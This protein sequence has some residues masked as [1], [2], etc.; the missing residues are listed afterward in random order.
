MPSPQTNVVIRKYQPRDRAAVH[1]LTC[2]TALMGEPCG[3]FFDGD[4]VFAQAVS[5]YFTGYE[6]ESC[7]VAVDGDRVVG[8]LTGAKDARRVNTVFRRRIALPLFVR[9][10]ATGVFC[11][12]K[13]LVFLARFLANLFKG[14]FGAPASCLRDYPAVMHLNIETGYRGSGLGRRL[15]DAYCAYLRQNNVKAVSLATMSGRTGRFFARQGFQLLFTGKR[16]YLRHVLH[17]DV[18]IYIYGKRLD[19]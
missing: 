16:S 9:A 19:G 2:A 6:P 13:N 7:F 3:I 5:G 10:L 15:V 1:R 4:D 11:K 12:K 8:Y 14:E 17:K 18:P